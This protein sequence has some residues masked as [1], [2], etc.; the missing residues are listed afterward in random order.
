VITVYDGTTLLG[1]VAAGTGGAWSFISPVLGE[2]SH[3]LTVRVTDAAGNTS[4]ASS[5]ATV[6]VDTVVPTAVSGL[7]AANNNGSSPVT[8]AAGGNT[9]DNTPALSGTA[10]AGSVVV[11]RDGVDIIGSVTAGSNGAWSFT[12]PTLADGLHTL[13]V[14]ATDLAGN[15][16]PNAAISFTVTTAAPTPVTDLVVSDNVGATQ[17]ALTS[18]AA[19]DDNTPT[20]SGNA[21]AGNI[22][23]ISEGTMVRGALPQPH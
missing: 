19:T 22:V 21:T 1:S 7:T 16:S 13:N 10:E 20:L 12:S 6:T 2:G 4:A 15:V 5:T 14:T 17:G 3:S 9:N 18:G 11:I 23:I 8:I